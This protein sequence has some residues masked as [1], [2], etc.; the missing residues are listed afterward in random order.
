MLKTIGI[1]A[2]AAL[3][4]SFATVQFTGITGSADTPSGFDPAELDALA[5]Q[6]AQHDALKMQFKP[7]SLLMTPES[8]EDAWLNGRAA[9]GSPRPGPADDV[10]A[11]VSAENS[12]CFL[13]HVQVEGMN[14]TT[15][16][17]ACHVSVDEFTGFWEVHAVQGDGTDA[18]VRCNASCLVLQ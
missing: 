18:S 14:D 6:L 13:T 8:E 10:K 1:S 17:L 7:S 4:A 9:D 12:V 5:A 2:L 11:L 15:D 3:L 16:Q